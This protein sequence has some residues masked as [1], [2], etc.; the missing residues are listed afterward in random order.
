LPLNFTIALSE[1]I[2]I[3][4]IEIFSMEDFSSPIRLIQ[5][6]LH[7]LEDQKFSLQMNGLI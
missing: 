3:K 5:V 6:I 1:D 4:N 2:K 7:S